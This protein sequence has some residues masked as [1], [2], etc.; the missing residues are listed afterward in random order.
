MSTTVYQIILESSATPIRIGRGPQGG[1]HPQ[2]EKPR[3][4]YTETGF[5][6]LWDY[7]LAEFLTTL[8]QP[9]T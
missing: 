6:D 5:L 4:C 7:G 8:S 1:G 9:H 2:L 3:I